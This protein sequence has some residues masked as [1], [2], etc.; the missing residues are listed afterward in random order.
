MPHFTDTKNRRWDLTLNVNAVKRVRDLAGVNLM[1]VLDEPQLLA[2]LSADP[3]LFVDGIFAVVMPQAKDLGV[4]DE[5][6][7]ESFDGSTI[8]DATSAF[9]EAIVDFF[10]GARRKTLEKV[11]G[12]AATMVASQ[13]A[14]L[15]TALSDGTIDRAIDEAMAAIASSG[16]LPEKPASIPAS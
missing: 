3:I 13:E 15:A 14:K 11:L 4:T 9:L 5:Q 8:E 6:F 7:G 16:P 12:R 1:R 2:E 10:P